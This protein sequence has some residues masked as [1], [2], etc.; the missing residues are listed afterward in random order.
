MTPRFRTTLGFLLVVMLLA[1]SPIRLSGFGDAGHR[2]MGLIAERHLQ[3]SRAL[4]EVRRILASGETLAD[5]AVWPDVIKNP[6][7]EDEDTA[8]FR[9]DHPGHDTYHYANLP[10]QADRY[11]LSV[12]GARPTDMVQTMRESIRV[13]QGKS[14]LFRP[15]EALRVLAHLIGDVHQPLHIGNAF[16]S[17]EAPLRFVVPQ[18]ATGWHT[19]LG[20][21]LLLYGPQDRFNL[22]SYWD[23]HAVNISM[24]KDDAAAYARRLFDEVSVRPEWRGQGEVDTW[25]AQWA[26]ESLALARDVHEGIAIVTR[27]GPDDAKRNPRRWR[28]TQPDGYDALA[29]QRIPAQLAAAGFRLA[30]ALKAVW[31]DEK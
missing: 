4:A 11:D 15:R 13:L 24:R 5:A 27:L 16:V 25:P 1:V 7:Y 23:V 3:N 18:G 28:I 30:A 9:L 29:R 14:T 2:V 31:P 8:R 20:G 17:A 21:N 26:T 10:F 6:L 22:H 19:T 12:T